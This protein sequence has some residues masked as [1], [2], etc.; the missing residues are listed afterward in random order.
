MMRKFLAIKSVLAVLLLAFMSLS[1]LAGYPVTVIDERG[2]EITLP[3]KPERIITILPLYA[4]IV[5]DLEAKDRI[6]GV[7]DSPDN[8][9]EVADLP[10]VGTAFSPSVEA[11][12]ALKPDL[13]LG[14]F[15]PIRLTLEDAGIPVFLGGKPGGFIDRITEI[16]KLIRNVGLLLWGETEKADKLIGRLAEEII[17]IEEK[18]L[19]LPKVTV[20]VLYR[21]SFEALPYAPGPGSPEHEIV[22]RAGGLDVFSDIPPYGGE[23]SLE[24]LLER[25]PEVIITDPAHVK[26][27]TEDERLKG[28]QAVQSGKVFGVKASQWTSS[29][30]A[31]TLQA[32]AQILHPEAFK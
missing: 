11:I 12:L 19:D 25:N 8:P 28:L 26:F 29:R 23:V 6:V 27:I 20:A 18:L 7:A 17:A 2:K 5:I 32:V 1:L 9:P 15:D 13:V 4:E 21:G 22:T 16:F 31:Q 24:A 14:A 30:I 10:K 3:Q